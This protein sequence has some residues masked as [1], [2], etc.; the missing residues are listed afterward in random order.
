[1]LDS[2]SFTGHCKAQ[3]PF[4]KYSALWPDGLDALQIEQACIVRGGK[5]LN[6]SG[7]ECGLGLFHHYKAAQK[8][9]WP[10]DDHHRWSDLMLSEILQNK[11]TAII[12]PKDAAKTYTM[13][14]YGLTDYLMFPDETL[15]LM[16]ST[17]VRG[18]ELRVWGAVKDL[19][20][21]AKDRYDWL[22]GAPIDSKHALCTDSLA[23]DM[24]IVR[25]MR[26]GILCFA[27]GTLVDTP[28]GP[29][30][31]E[32]LSV[33]DEVLNAIG[34]GTVKIAFRRTADTLVRVTLSD[35][36]AI[37]CTPEHPFFTQRGWIKA[38]C[39]ETCD[40]VFS[41][42]ETLSLLQQTSRTR[43]SKSHVLLPAL[44]APEIL[45]KEMRSMPKRVPAMAATRG[46]ILLS[47]VC[48]AMGGGPPFQKTQT[49]REMRALWEDDEAGTHQPEVLFASL[50]EQSEAFTVQGMWPGIYFDPAVSE[51]RTH[52]FLQRVLQSEIEWPENW[53]EPSRTH[54]SRTQ[55]SFLVSTGGASPPNIDRQKNRS[56]LRSLS[57]SRSGFSRT[58]VSRGNRRRNSSDTGQSRERHQADKIP[59]QTWVVGVEILER[60]GDERFRQ[61]EGGYSVHNLEVSGHPSYSVNGVIVHNCVPCRSTSGAWLGLNNFV[62]LKQKRRRLLSDEVQFMAQAFM[63]APASLDGINFKAVYVGHP[64][65][66]GDP[67]DKLAE[68]KN[69]WGTEGDI[70]KTTVWENKFLGGRTIN[71][72]GTDS[73]NFDTPSPNLSYLIDQKMID[74]VVSFYTKDSSQYWSKCMGVRRTG[75]FAHRVITI[76]LCEQFRAFD[77]VIWKGTPTTK[78]YAFDPAFGGI[79]G[80]R[81]VGGAAEFGTDVEGRTILLI[82]PPVIIPVSVRYDMPAE[83]QIATYVM[84]DCIRKNIPPE[85]VFFDSTAR[86]GG[87]VAAF[88]RIW[89]PAVNPVEFGGKATERPVTLDHFTKDSQTGQRR[90]KKCSEEYSKF[91]TELWFSV[92]YAIESGQIRELSRE[93]AEEGCQREWIEVSGGRTELET[94]GDMKERTGRSPDLFDQLAIAVEGARRKGFAISKLANAEAEEAD[95]A[96]LD[97]LARKAQE[98]RTAHTLNYA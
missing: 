76:K 8:L 67:L 97:E 30:R 59:E 71:L 77:K 96:W 38:A 34:I 35:G 68:P 94:K 25:D 55:G 3:M 23:E 62:G 22:A 83:D 41:A 78:V 63:E 92:R 48:G 69:G 85:N 91:V 29:K 88:A 49:R 58:E 20:R 61:S 80:D 21:R 74:G 81:C 11:H 12:G 4:Q 54:G 56:R 32:S 19:W 95:H 43:L 7:V 87:I 17:D 86:G 15:I 33:G 14:R 82:H 57:R 90:L 26:K 72:V 64:L 40:L 28:T 75:M 31:I 27:A 50:P 65:G 89:S 10:E 13:A 60:G 9:M 39:L 46:E 70:T 36:R 52:Q 44:P 45:R 2:P 79:G 47:G 1:M 16:S 37:D 51:A 73:P 6:K 84:N 53:Q 24:D 5:W 18:L 66:Q 98:R 93:V 42:D